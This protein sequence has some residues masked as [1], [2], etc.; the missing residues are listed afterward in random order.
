MDAPDLLSEFQDRHADHLVYEGP[1]RLLADE[2]L[3]RAHADLAGLFEEW[4]Q[5][6]YHFDNDLGASAVLYRPIRRRGM[7]WDLMVARFRGDDPFAFVRAGAF[8]RDLRWRDV[9]AILDRIREG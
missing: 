7:R 3:E 9:Q 5:R 8:R 4:R 6:I 1:Y 2:A